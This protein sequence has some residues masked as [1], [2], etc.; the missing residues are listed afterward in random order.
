M[1]FSLRQL[2][3]V[4]AIAQ[5]G[6]TARAAQALNLSQSAVSAALQNL[7]STYSVKLYDRIGRRLELNPLG[8]AVK[9]RASSMLAQAQDLERLLLQSTL[10]DQIRIGASHTIANHVLVDYI[11]DFHRLYPETRIEVSSGNSPAIIEQVI[12]HQVEL[13]LIENDMNH[14]ELSFE[15][16]LSDELV[17]FAAPNNPLC[18]IAVLNDKHLSQQPWILREPSS[19]TRQRFDQ[20]F[21]HLLSKLDVRYEFR[22]N[23]PIKRAVEQGLGLGCLSSRALASEIHD[24]RLVPLRL[25]SRYSMQRR[26]FMITPSGGYEPEGVQR[27]KQICQPIDRSL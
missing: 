20:A 26:F 18:D 1:R 12:S 15:P 2:E 24:G 8:Q 5:H 22:H 4:Q 14:P 3:V 25:S 7:E 6:T 19:G 17:V 9:R 13:G 16:W 27:F 23:E 21:S 10:P 11:A